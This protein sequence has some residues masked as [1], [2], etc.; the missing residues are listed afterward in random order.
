MKRILAL[1]SCMLL[2]I[3]CFASQEPPIQ[4]QSGFYIGAQYV[5][6]VGVGTDIG[7]QFNPYVALEAQAVA[8]FQ[9]YFGGIS[10]KGILPTSQHTNLYAKLG[11]VGGTGI[12]GD[13]RPGAAAFAGLGLGVYACKHLEFNFE[14]NGAAGSFYDGD[15]RIGF[16]V[17]F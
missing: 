4:Q 5:G 10:V 16:T 13:S 2:S 14:V 9:A 11:I 6:M 15:A 12:L 17:H 1:I 8:S 3:S 7:Y